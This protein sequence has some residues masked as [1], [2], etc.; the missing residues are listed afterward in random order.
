MTDQ[1]MWVSGHTKLV[2]IYAF[3]ISCKQNQHEFQQ[4]KNDEKKT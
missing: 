4:E 1:H 2:I 3:S